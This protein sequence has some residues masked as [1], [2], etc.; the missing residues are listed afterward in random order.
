MKILEYIC[1]ICDQKISLDQYK[2]G[3]PWNILIV[4][5]ELEHHYCGKCMLNIANAIYILKRKVEK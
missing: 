3:R 1:D 2:D 4:G 5:G